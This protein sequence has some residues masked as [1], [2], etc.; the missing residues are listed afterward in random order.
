MG[1]SHPESNFSNL[2]TFEILL[3]A[4]LSWSKV[5]RLFP[6]ENFHFSI[7]FS[8]IFFSIQIF[9]FF[10]LSWDFFNFLP[11]NFPFF[12]VVR[13][14]F[15]QFL[16]FEII[17]G[18]FLRFLSQNSG[19]IPLN[20]ENNNLRFGYFFDRIS[21]KKPPL[22]WRC[23]RWG[24]DAPT[25]SAHRNPASRSPEYE[26]A[27]EKR[28]DT[29]FE[30]RSLKLKT[31]LKESHNLWLIKKEMWIEGPTINWQSPRFYLWP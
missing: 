20:F 19:R 24:S 7:F 15:S 1:F 18:L 11:F 14:T 27:P 12:F 25:R 30:N 16:S 17:V 2:G 26:Q 10:E 3:D 6:F 4:S 13:K 23:R 29:L 22:P 31:C 8:Q 9:F 21:Y 28:F 5:S